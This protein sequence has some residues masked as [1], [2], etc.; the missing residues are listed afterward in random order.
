MTNAS[1]KIFDSGAGVTTRAG[2][3]VGRALELLTS[4]RA[5]RAFD[6]SKEPAAVRDR[7]G[8]DVNGQSFLLAR[9]LVEAG[10]P[11]V[12]VHW[13][14]RR[15]GAGLSWDTHT[16]NFGQLADTWRTEVKLK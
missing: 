1:R 6:V 14:G 3:L 7:Y 11:F 10:V 2:A 8:D 15:F 13:L 16:D 12:C 5:R 9:R 4:A